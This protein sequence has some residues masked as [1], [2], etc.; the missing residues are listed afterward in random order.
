MLPCSKRRFSSK[1]TSSR[2]PI[3]KISIVFLL[4]VILMS[5]QLQA[6]DTK[7]TVHNETD[8]GITVNIYGGYCA[9]HTGNG[10]AKG[11]SN[12]WVV[13]GCGADMSIWFPGGWYSSI[14]T[15]AATWGNNSYD[16]KAKKIKNQHGKEQY[17]VEDGG[18]KY[19]AV[20]E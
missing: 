5:V 7:I 16:L 15:K 11:Q 10:I 12:F 8:D 17:V 3:M 4:P 14:R 2:R 13:G 18:N 9:D 19:W 1:K 6:F 20:K